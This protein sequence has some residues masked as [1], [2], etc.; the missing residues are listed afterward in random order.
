MGSFGNQL[1][2]ILRRLG[3]SPGFTAITLLTLAIGIGATT[4]IF[5]VVD[6]VL[7]KPLP[8]PHPEQLVGLWHNP[9]GLKSPEWNMAPGNYF[10][11]REQSRTFQD[12]GLFSGDTVSVTG[13]QEPERVRAM[14]VTDGTLPILGVP[15]RLGRGF[16]RSDDSAGTPLT[17][18]LG[19]SYWQRRFGGNNSV[20]GRTITLDGQVCQIVGVM[21]RGFHFLDYEEPAVYLP[22]QLDRNKTYL[23]G[24]HFQG[25]ARL[26]PGATL[27]AANADV[28][29]MLPIVFRSFAPPPGL[30]LKVFEDARFVP[31]LHPLKQDVVGDIG[32]VLWVLMGSISIVLLIACA[33]VA[34]L[35]LVQA[36][37]RQQELAIRTAL[38]ASRA[39]IATSLL[40]ESIAIGMLGGLLGLGFASLT[41]QLLTALAPP[42]LP[43]LQEIGIDFPVLIFALLVSL[44]ASMLSGIIPVLKYSGLQAATGLRESGRTASQGRERHRARNALVVIQVGLA[45]VLLMCSG[46]MIRTFR[47]L[48]R[49]DPGFTGPATIQTFRINIPEAAVPKAEAVTRMQQSIQE[50]IAAI[51]GVSSATLTYSVPMDGY[52]W[53]DAVFRQDVSASENESPPLRQFRFVSP[54]F[55]HTLGIPLVAGRD[56][57]WAD[58][59]QEL[60]VVLVSENFARECWGS[61]DKALGKQIRAGLTDDWREI[62]GVAAD[63]RDNGANQ[64][65]PTS[66]YWPVLVKS[67]EGDNEVEARRAVAYVIRT[68]RAGSQSLMKEISNAVWS[69]DASLPLADIH[70][71]DYF[72]RQS[73]ARTSFTLVMLGIAG[74]AGLL[75]GIVGL[76]S[77]IAYSVAQRRKE[78]GIRMAL[79]AQ[80]DALVRMFVRQGLILTSLGV[81]CGLA[82]AAGLTRLMASL[83]FHVSSL[84]PLTYCAVTAVLIATAMLA[85]YLPSRRAATVDPVETLRAE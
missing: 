65:A 46:L 45:F 27:A 40:L 49:V 41:L 51:P 32:G 80:R 35:L 81:V 5:S 52:D 77:V 9:L 38:G 67:F 19:Y 15:P 8:Y 69:V 64:D 28:A 63:V 12:V 4:A 75:L 26:K 22:F 60:P 36:E 13:G 7:L 29:R 2:Q 55:F 58:T 57:T 16:S 68:P 78:I 73:M 14:R 59:Y 50:K 71:L 6:G 31:D 17:A 20:L 61:P 21:P 3:R 83:L 25:V 85:S 11:Y 48:S 76:Y 42:G 56:F 34:N 82:A 66:V 33:N 74:A 72:Y 70:T 47:V 24:F 1:K 79:G 43:R 37:G 30:T 54:G 10:I 62:V 23:G 18:I 53:G 39:R 84:D 44:M